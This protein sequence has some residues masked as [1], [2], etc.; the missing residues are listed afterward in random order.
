MGKIIGEYEIGEASLQQMRERKGT[1]AAYQC[2]AL[3]STNIGTM[4]FLKV[5]QGCTYETAP[6]TL[7]DSHLGT[8]WSFTLVGFVD[9]DSGKIIEE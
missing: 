4:R 9:L 2:H 1:W 8:G 6:A 7:P 3:D 5:G